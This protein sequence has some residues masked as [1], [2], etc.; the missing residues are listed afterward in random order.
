MSGTSSGPSPFAEPGD[1]AAALAAGA[2][3]LR[4]TAAGSV[5]IA[6]VLAGGIVAVNSGNNLLYFVVAVLLALFGLSGVLGHR[7][8][9]G[10]TLR[11]LAPE[12]AW[13]GRPVAVR[14]LLGAGPSRDSYLLTVGGHG[15]TASP[16]AVVVPRGGRESL[17]LAVSFPA[18]GRQP[19]PQV[20]VSS[21]FPF[22]LI[23]RARTV[24]PPG[25]C[26]VYPQPLPVSWERVDRAEREGE[27]AAAR[28][29]TGFGGDY[30][31]LRD[32]IAGDRISRVQWKSWLRLRRLQT[33]EFETEG[34]P[35]VVYAFDA[36]P[37]PG[38]EERL[39]QLAWLV[40]TAL[41]RGRAA[42][43]ELP[44]RAIPPGSGAAH[45]RVLLAALA[46]FGEPA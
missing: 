37:G 5:A 32:Y 18:R 26:L 44:G 36:V 29:E 16:T 39:G 35:P 3:R 46:R 15:A 34:A 42:G 12:E 24:T 45:R 25:G 43:L 40:R 17:E 4:L 9:A 22:G 13:A 20:E 21:E 6:L 10:V 14:A 7:N 31:G 30:R 1:G 2:L 38:T 11:L 8:L 23:R 19:W 41:R 27:L 28:R 33:K